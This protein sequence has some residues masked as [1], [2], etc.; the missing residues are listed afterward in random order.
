MKVP[1]PRLRQVFEH[2]T[3]FRVQKPGAAKPI[4]IAKSALSPNMVTKLRKF[5]RGGVPTQEE[6]D[7]AA[8]AA[9]VA[10]F[11]SE[12]SVITPAESL[13]PAAA[14]MPAATY[15]D[16]VKAYEQEFNKDQPDENEL[17]F[18]SETMRAMKPAA[19]A[20]AAALVPAA[21]SPAAPA[22][23][24]KQEPLPEIKYWDERSLRKMGRIGPDDVIEQATDISRP[25]RPE[26]GYSIINTKT[27][28]RYGFPISA[29]LMDR[30]SMFPPFGR[31]DESIE[32]PAPV[33]AVA[34]E[35]AF[36]MKV[37]EEV[38]AEEARAKN[39][40]IANAASEFAEAA[41]AD[42]SQVGKAQTKY[43]EKLNE[44]GLSP[45]EK[46]KSIQ[47]GQALYRSLRDTAAKEAMPPYLRLMAEHRE[48]FAKDE[49][50][51]DP[52][53]LKRLEQQM[54]SM[55]EAAKA[56]TPAPVA[57]V[58]AAPAQAPAPA[59]TPP[60]AAAPVAAPVA[61]APAVEPVA[62]PAAPVVAPAVVAPPAPV[63]PPTAIVAPAPVAAAP[64]VP[65]KAE[66]KIPEG[67]TDV[68]AESFKKALEANPTAD[69]A[70]VATALVRKVRPDIPPPDF[71]TLGARPEPAEG[72]TALDRFDAAV[73]KKSEA[74]TAEAEADFK[75][76]QDLAAIAQQAEAR[77]LMA[78]KKNEDVAKNLASR[79]EDLKTL[80]RQSEEEA[81][82][83]FFSRLDTGPK[84][85]SVIALAVGGF[86]SGSTGT[87]NYVYTAFN[88]AM[89][90][91]LENQKRRRD[92]ILKQYERVLGDEED[93]QKLARAD[94][95][96]LTS[97]QI[98]AV[99]ARSNL[100]AVAPQLQKLQADLDMEAA[101][102]REDVRKKMYDAD[103]AEINAK[104]QEEYRDALTEATKRRGL[105]VGRSPVSAE[106]LAF[107]K[108]Q[109][110]EGKRFTVPDPENPERS[111]VIE[112]LSKPAAQKSIQTI[113]Q[114][115]DGT[116]R[117]EEFLKFLAEN[118]DKPTTPELI[119]GMEIRL[120]GVVENYPGTF[121][122]SQNLVTTAQAKM[123]TPAV[124]DLGLPIVKYLDGLGMTTTAIKALR[125][126]AVRGVNLAVQGAAD[127]ADPGYQE[128]KRKWSSQGYRGRTGIPA[129]PRAAAVQQSAAGG[130]PSPAGMVKVRA[131]NGSVGL[132][133]Q[134]NLAKALRRGATVVP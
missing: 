112:G 27:G 86:L 30:A 29:P 14:P 77:Q 5:A 126:D 98:D 94:L 115:I 123:I 131:A 117:L 52:K 97:L 13:A 37:S 33:P 127:P 83:S 120:K 57:P 128:F 65:A 104:S 109:Y 4:T 18:L 53:K 106:R 111:I 85:G 35:P 132:I 68:S 50:D 130:A 25:G 63:A 55:R 21:P 26:I 7:A 36:T 1:R 119:R 44:L 124:E 56:K 92:S 96:N 67:V 34:S 91:D 15:E 105:G 41:A 6:A 61:A 114:R 38:A 84:I 76:R 60:V 59:A 79:R 73:A 88:N 24:A 31:A 32:P 62:A 12:E 122:G 43:I 110:L 10:S 39:E 42:P 103:I 58:A 102:L 51:R 2:T 66:I 72:E 28:K 101:K 82:K 133:P 100:R 19:P 20:P 48:E 17:Q 70:E 75:T 78:I 116:M 99:K 9:N 45:E 23:E 87:P 54:A 22:P 69:Q 8:K 90:R 11:G 3:T 108:A 74:L 64:A 80:Y 81:S 118:K 121:R 46:K 40:A 129:R 89:D 16:V 113:T 47:E 49:K 95:L 134:A 125:E 107:A 71:K 93:A